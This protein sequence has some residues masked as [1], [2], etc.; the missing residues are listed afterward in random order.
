M[1]GWPLRFCLC[2]TQIGI[3]TSVLCSWVYAHH[4]C[5]LCLV[6]RGCRGREA[7]SVTLPAER[8]FIL[9][10][11][12]PTQGEIVGRWCETT[13]LTAPATSPTTHT[14]DLSSP[15]F[16]TPPQ[17]QTQGQKHVCSQMHKERKRNIKCAYASVHHNLLSFT[18]RHTY[19]YL[20]S[21]ISHL[22]HLFLVRHKDAVYCIKLA[23][24]D[25]PFP[26]STFGRRPEDV[27]PTAPAT[28]PYAPL[29]HVVLSPCCAPMSNYN[30]DGRH[31]MI[32]L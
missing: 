12:E 3:S 31:Q 15:D 10:L 30:H 27:L 26:V 21:K 32:C 4:V 23:L 22:F 25:R 1:N 18:H 9:G 8:A 17:T 24:N 6:W 7:R 13:T 19:L 20:L 16:V 2:D 29:N 28:R 5:V 11:S 14:L